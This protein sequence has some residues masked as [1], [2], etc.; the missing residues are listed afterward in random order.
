MRSW[1]YS[2]GW[3]VSWKKKIIQCRL[4]SSASAHRN[5][6]TFL[7]LVAFFLYRSW[8]Q[9]IIHSFRQCTNVCT[10]SSPEQIPILKRGLFML[11]KETHN[12]QIIEYV[13]CLL[14]GLSLEFFVLSSLHFRPQHCK[15]SDVRN[16]QKRLALLQRPCKSF[17]ARLVDDCYT[18]EKESELE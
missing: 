11:C 13:T 7:I 8:L 14:V 6:W 10:I 2:S 5:L 4:L 1:N 12:R 17:F 16:I 18:K 3:Q 9:W 15:H